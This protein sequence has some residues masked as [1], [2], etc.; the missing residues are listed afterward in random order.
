MTFLRLLAVAQATLLLAGCGGPSAELDVI[1]SIEGD[2]V[3]AW[4]TEDVLLHRIE[5]RDSHGAPLIVRR[6]SQPGIYLVTSPALTAGATYTVVVQSVDG[7]EGRSEVTAP[8]VGPV[9]VLV[10]APRGQEPIPLTPGATMSYGMVEGLDTHVAFRLEAL[11]SGVVTVEVCGQVHR[12]QFQVP[13]EKRELA[14]HMPPGLS[15]TGRVADGPEFTLVPIVSTLAEARA[16]IRIERVV[17]P[18]DTTGQPD[19]ARPA[20][21]ITLPSPGW[22]SLLRN[23]PM[24]ARGRAVEAPW[25]STAVHVRNDS[26]RPLNAVVRLAIRAPDGGP[27]APFRPRM[28]LFDG[29]TGQVTGLLRVPAG[30]TSVATLPVF[31]DDALL[32]PGSSTWLR[33]LEVTPLG[34]DVALVSDEAILVVSRGSS[35]RSFGFAGAMF[36]ALLGLL[37]IATKL[38]GWLRSARTSDLVTIALFANLMFVF[39][40][41]SH[42][43]GLGAATVLG[44]FSSL[45][46]GLVDD[47][48]RYALLASLVTLLPRPGVVTLALLVHYLMRGLALGGFHPTDPLIVGNSVLWLEGGLYLFGITRGDGGWRD[49]GPIRRW[50]RLSGAFGAASVAMAAIALVSAA[51]LYRLYYADWY[52]W[53]MLGL[54]GLLYTVIACWVATGFAGSLRE[55]EA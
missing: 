21:R 27:A 36:T 48:F 30:H 6:Y 4:T 26:D 29:D 25:S 51:V 38:G 28:R 46:T 15:C 44:P 13:G 41:A 31:V 16:A 32:P 34:S 7:R 19:P 2:E 47:A 54:P 40:A 9:R 3:R 5:V 43:L 35:T 37:L 8:D 10:E 17:F 42:L 12:V 11:R 33:R 1:A 45:V 18:A 23:T 22:A 14:V 55:V 49:E 50:L 20:D 24:G 53:M 52:V 39:S